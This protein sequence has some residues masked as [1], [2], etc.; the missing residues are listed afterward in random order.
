MPAVFSAHSASRTYLKGTNTEL[1]QDLVRGRDANGE[2]SKHHVV[3][4]EEWD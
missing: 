2:G 3:D 1:K 4:T